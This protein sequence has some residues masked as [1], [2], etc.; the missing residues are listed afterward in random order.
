[1]KT[2]YVVVLVVLDLVLLGAT[3]GAFFSIGLNVGK[4][5]MRAAARQ[6]FQFLGDIHRRSLETLVGELTKKDGN[7]AALERLKEFQKAC[8]GERPDIRIVV[9]GMDQLFAPELST[10]QDYAAL[11]KKMQSE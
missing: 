2:K 3:A 8:D 6:Q 11:L 9:R 1:M 7:A 10:R 4:E 5:D